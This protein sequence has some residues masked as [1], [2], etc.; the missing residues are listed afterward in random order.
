MASAPREYYDDSIEPGPYDLVRFASGDFSGL[1]LEH[2]VY[3]SWDLLYAALG[4]KTDGFWGW[5]THAAYLNTIVEAV[6]A[7]PSPDREAIIAELKR[8]RNS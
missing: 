6:N 5:M 4:K 8:L 3:P 2:E 1:I 7:L